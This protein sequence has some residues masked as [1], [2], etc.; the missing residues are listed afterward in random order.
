MKINI[1]CPINDTGYG[2]SSYNIWSKFYNMYPNTT[3]LFPIGG[4]NIEDNISIKNNITHSIKN[5]SIS[6]ADSCCLKIWHMHDLFSRI[7]HGQYL[8]LPFFETD[9]LTVSEKAA[10]SHVDTI[11]TTTD[12]SKDVLIN[13]GIDSQ[14]IHLCPLGV[15]HNIFD[16]AQPNDREDGPYVF[17][18]IGK[19]EIR[20]SH[21]ILIEAFN[22]AF[23]KEDKVELWMVNQNPFLSKEQNYEWI[24]LYKQSKLGDKIKIFPRFQS[25]KN[26]ASLIAYADCGVYISRAEGWNNEILETM[27]M[28]KPIIATNYSAHTEYCNKD[29]SYLVDIDELEIAVDNRWFDGSRGR[30]AKIGSKQISSI[31]DNMRYVVKNNIKVN[32]NGLQT[33]KIYTWDNTVNHIMKAVR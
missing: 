17:I 30:W 21:D 22:A 15:D 4:I 5:Q 2:I 33:S 3:T 6:S 16:G 10:L 25:H 32:P 11:L 20:K 29:N 18:N 7:G 1:N 19:W 26:I 12:W 28:N 9:L 13:N 31:I 24:N 27:A 14:K 8:A 23:D